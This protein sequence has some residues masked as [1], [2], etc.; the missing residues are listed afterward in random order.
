M[1][2]LHINQ[3]DLSGGAA[4][5]GYNLHQALLNQ[6][7][8]SCLLVERVTT[9][10]E[11]VK[12]IP[13]KR[14]FEGKIASITRRLG[15]NYLEYLG[16][17]EIKKHPFYEKADV[18]NLHNLHGAT[19]NY[20][21]LAPLTHDKPAIWTLHDMWSFTGH[22]SY[23]YDCERW[24]LGC[25]NCPYPKIYPAIKKDNTNLEWKLKNWVYSR[26]NLTIVTPSKW[27]AEQAE[28]SML[29]RFSIHH[30]PNGIDLNTYYPLDSKKCREFLDIPPDKKVLL[31]GAASMTDTRKGGKL[32]FEALSQLPN[33]LK[34]E[35]ILLTLGQGGKALGQTLGIESI[36]LGYLSYN[37]F[38]SV[39]YSAADLFI[40]P[41]RADNLP[42]VLQ[43]SMA[44][45]TPMISFDIGGVSDLVRP[46]LT[47]YLAKPE[48][49][50]DLMTGIVQLLEDRELRERLSQTCRQI[51]V[52]EYSQELQ[53]QRYVEL[54]DQVLSR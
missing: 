54:Y 22:C 32:L 3:S 29:N 12:G 41:T 19:F 1:K 39:A 13:R 27:L 6:A 38:K 35:I 17:F 34:S 11:L 37:R 16:S 21:A 33:S 25:G 28:Q 20:L 50:Q 48:D 52:K 4:I 36:N 45:G 9:E 26:S 49:P 31:F 46:D 51:A 8:D 18:I 30:I 42:L 10:D 2:I 23:S 44:C 40:L 24:K 5:A 53:G 43:E 15:L 47:G 7:I 14:K